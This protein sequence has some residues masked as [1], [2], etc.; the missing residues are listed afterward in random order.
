MMLTRVI[1]TYLAH[2]AVH[3]DVVQRDDGSVDPESDRGYIPAARHEG[4]YR[5]RVFTRRQLPSEIAADLAGKPAI[6]NALEKLPM[7]AGPGPGEHEHAAYPWTGEET[8][9]RRAEMILAVDES[10]GQPRKGAG[11][12]VR[13]PPRSPVEGA[14]NPRSRWR[15]RCAACCCTRPYRPARR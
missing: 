1:A 3:P 6:R 5:D 14:Q 2:K 7:A 15:W 13:S 8:I 4:R 9:R 11:R 12:F 10:L